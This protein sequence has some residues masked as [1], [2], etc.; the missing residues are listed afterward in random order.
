MDQNEQETKRVM[1][2]LAS[3][4]QEEVIRLGARI[5]E[6]VVE[7]TPVD[8]GFARSN[9]IPSIGVPFEQIV[10]RKWKIGKKFFAQLNEAAQRSG[11]AS[12]LTWKIGQGDIFI[13][14]N[15]PYINRL[16]EGWHERMDR[17]HFVEMAIQRSV[18]EI[19]SKVPVEV[20]KTQT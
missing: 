7:S 10:G 16:N 13:A 4:L 19:G 8:T 17:F 11:K 5:H 9:W 12:L 1:K 2:E 6:E 15:V 18:E 20:V 14:N 3:E